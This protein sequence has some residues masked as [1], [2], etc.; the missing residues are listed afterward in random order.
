MQTRQS[1]GEEAAPSEHTS[2]TAARGEPTAP[3]TLG[4]AGRRLACL[5][6]NIYQPCLELKYYCHGKFTGD[7]SQMVL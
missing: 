1:E 6:F 7:G 5:F 3:L 4:R 2:I